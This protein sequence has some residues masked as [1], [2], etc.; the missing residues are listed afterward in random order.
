MPFIVFIVKNI[1]AAILSLCFALATSPVCP[2][3]NGKGK[4]DKESG[5]TESD[6]FSDFLNGAANAAKKNSGKGDGNGKR[7]GMKNKDELAALV[8]ASATAS[9]P[10]LA[11]MDFDAYATKLA[12]T[13]DMLTAEQQD[14]IFR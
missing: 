8:K 10:K 2:G 14:R 3:G 9:D 7:Y 13:L 11:N 12:K 1:K 4:D 5:D 6:S